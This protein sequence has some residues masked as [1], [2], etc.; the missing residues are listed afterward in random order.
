[1]TMS[2]I[3]TE[4]SPRR[5]LL[6]R[7]LAWMLAVFLVHL[8]L[9]IAVLGRPDAFGLPFV[10]KFDWYIFHAAFFDVRWISWLSAFFVAHVAFWETR[11]RR[12]AHAGLWALYLV[13]AVLLVATLIDDETYRFMG[14]HL[15]PSLFTTYGNGAATR[16]VFNFLADDKGGRYLPLVLLALM[17]P[18]AIGLTR[19]LR[20]RTVFSDHP[21]WKPFL[22]TLLIA[23]AV[24][25][26][27]TEVIWTGG[28]RAKK[29]APVQEV[30]W[31]ELRQKHSQYIG[32]AEFRNL[33]N[34]FRSRWKTENVSDTLWDF[35]DSNL[36]YWKVPRGGLHVAPR[37][38]QWNIVLIVLESHRALNCGFLMP[39]GAVRDATPFLDS[40]APK[41]EI[42]TRYQC[43]ALPTVRALASLHLGILN[44]P[45]RNFTSDNPTLANTSLP[46]I[47]GHAGWTTRFFSAAD[48]AWDNQTPWLRQWYQGFD[49][50]RSRESDAELFSHASHWMHDS[51]NVGKPFFVAFMSKTNHYPFNP[52]PG[53]EAAPNG[54]LQAR[55]R[56]TMRYTD[57]SVATFVNSLRHEPWFSRTIF[58]ITGDHGFPLGE[59]GSSNIGYGLYSESDWL[60]LVIFGNHPRLHAGQV[61]PEPASHL[62]LGPTLLSLAG[63]RAA[64]HFTGRDLFSPVPARLQ[65]TTTQGDEVLAVTSSLRVHGTLSGGVREH[66]NEVFSAQDIRETHPLPTDAAVTTPILKASREESRLLEAV[67]QRDALAPRKP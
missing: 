55:M 42:W 34:A 24:G 47:L 50:D 12:W 54:D 39:Y 46:A 57:H 51:L 41:A 62:D 44:H 5:P 15:T 40:V 11:K 59:H 1:M 48:P 49:Y 2:P 25:W 16:Q 23:N 60:P 14:C 64:N 36:P 32:D 19:W 52:E 29:L 53:V 8:V 9:R 56:A 28:F 33:T 17:L 31:T 18:L 61:H 6:A 66:G 27:Y 13:H 4:S 22:I 7:S 3:A 37:D 65:R 26:L 21:R 38:S 63:V 67:L 10:G 35:P 45:S 43:P 20:R 30:W 58:V